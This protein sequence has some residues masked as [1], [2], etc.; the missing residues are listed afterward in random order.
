M[1]GSKEHFIRV[2]A[3]ETARGFADARRN[4][5]R[6]AGLKIHD[7]DLVERIVGFTLA[8]ENQRF[9]VR[10]EVSLAA[11]FALEGELADI[12]EERR[13]VLGRECH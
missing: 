5:M 7:V 12:L 6:V 3:E 2:G 11:A 9:A 4:A 8:L 10:R 1:R 13:F